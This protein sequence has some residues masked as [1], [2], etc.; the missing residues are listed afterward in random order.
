MKFEQIMN[1]ILYKGL[2]IMML[3]GTGAAQAQPNEFCGIKNRSFRS[4]E[5]VVFKVFYNMGMIWAGAGTATFTTQLTTY[6]NKPVYYVK[7][8]GQTFSSYEWF[9]KVYDVYESYIDTANLMPIK[10][11]RDVNEGGFK[12][13]NNV[14]FNH[15]RNQAISTNGVFNIPDCVQDVLSTVYYARNIDYSKYKPGDKIPFNMFLDDQVY[16]LYIR[17]VGKEIIKTKYGTFRAIKIAPLLIEGTMF[18]GGEKMMVWVTDDENHIPVRID[19]PIA[20]GSIKVDLMEY[21]NLR[22]P[23]SALLKKK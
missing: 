22:H 11:L 13:K 4:G 5:K 2:V 14:T 15:S 6:N 9:Y 23:M 8:V 17:Y 20:I 19:S 16:S 21:Q 12:F 18:K 7:G 10:F 1:R 3:M